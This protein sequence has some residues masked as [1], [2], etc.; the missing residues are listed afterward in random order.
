MTSPG[1]ALRLLAPPAAVLAAA[2]AGMGVVWGAGR[3][4]LPPPPLLHPTGLETWWRQAGP[5][6]AL[7]SLARCA[8]VVMALLAALCS[9]AVLAARLVLVAGTTGVG[10]WAWAA[11][12]AEP[13]GRSR[14]GRLLLGLLGLSA[15]G[16]LLAGCG[17]HGGRAVPPAPG[18]TTTGGST[19]SG[20][21]YRVPPAPELLGPAGGT[22]GGLMLAG[23][24]GGPGPPTVGAPPRP[25]APRPKAPRPRAPRPPGAPTSAASPPL[26]WTVRPGDDFWS[27]AEAVVGGAAGGGTGGPGAIQ[28]APYWSRL[29]A[30]NRDRLPV[31]GDP[32]LLFPGDVV[33][34][35]PLG[36]TAVA[37]D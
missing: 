7:F 26:T 28:V 1:A 16:G 9:A 3:T 10:A 12:L 27:I 32:G 19:A 35:P 8:V 22:A 11:R 31:P 23:S 20:A 36:R 29:V 2:T 33:V 4:I 34:L 37:P 13:G 30:A 6:G 5:V 18:A 21:P 14:I 15:S 25:K 17:L 24:G